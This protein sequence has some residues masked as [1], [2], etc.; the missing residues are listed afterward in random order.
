MSEYTA[1]YEQTRDGWWAH[2]PDLPGCTAF[3]T[4][5]AEAE[6]DAREAVAAHVALLRDTGRP[7]P[8]PTRTAV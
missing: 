8:E 5:R 7:V 3:G 6:R 2:F 1:I 4:T